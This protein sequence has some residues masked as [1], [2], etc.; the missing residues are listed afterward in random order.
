MFPAI[1]YKYDP[2]IFY[3]VTAPNTDF[4]QFKINKISNCGYLY[5]RKYEVTMFPA[6]FYKYY[7][8]AIFY[9]VTAPNTDFS[10]FKI[11]K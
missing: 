1:F 10:Q 11:N 5:T 3:I 9:I 2:A 6:I 7:D 8:P 4:S